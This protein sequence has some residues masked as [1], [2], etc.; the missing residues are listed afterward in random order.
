MSQGGIVA[1]STCD[2]AGERLGWGEFVATTG[3]RSIKPPIK[4]LAA[5]LLLQKK[6]LVQCR[7][8]CVVA[9]VVVVV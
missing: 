6:E 8:E 9:V 3:Y 4:C 7:I 5:C 1:R 2:L